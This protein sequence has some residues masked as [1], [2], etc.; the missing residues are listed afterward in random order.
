MSYIFVSVGECLHVHPHADM[1]TY[2]QIYI[3]SICM[4]CI[5]TSCICVSVGEYLHI[6]T[7]SDINT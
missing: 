6:Y 5:Y 1:N 3:F 2:V 4:F 7:R